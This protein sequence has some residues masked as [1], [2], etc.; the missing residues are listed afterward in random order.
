MI[1]IHL[2]RFSP[3][4]QIQCSGTPV[5]RITRKWNP[6]ITHLKNLNL[7]IIIKNK[8]KIRLIQQLRVI[9]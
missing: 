3:Q 9:N 8:V 7:C 6:V 4:L 2:I 5:D 1:F